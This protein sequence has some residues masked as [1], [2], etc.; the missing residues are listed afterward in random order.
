[1]VVQGDLAIDDRG[2]LRFVN[3]F[4]LRKYRRFYIVESHRSEFIRAWHGHKVEGKAFVV[5][6]GSALIGAVQIDDWDTPNPEAFV[7]RVVLS[8]GK[9]SVF[10]VP[11]GYA[12]GLMTLSADTQV[13]VFSTMLLADAIGDDFRFPARHW[14]IWTVDER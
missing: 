7:D 4:D 1:M 3:D 6:R 11:Q 9:P 5:T 10:V 2:S 14:D 8:A 12:N 13:L